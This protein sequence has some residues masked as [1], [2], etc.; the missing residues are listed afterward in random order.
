[1]SKG[2]VKEGKKTKEED[3][4]YDIVMNVMNYFLGEQANLFPFQRKKII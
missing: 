1:M 4:A 2:I 3:I